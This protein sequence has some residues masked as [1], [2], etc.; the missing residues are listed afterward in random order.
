VKISERIARLERD[1]R[2]AVVAAQSGKEWPHHAAQELHF[3]AQCIAVANQLRV[4]LQRSRADEELG[5]NC[6]AERA[7]G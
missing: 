2:I 4:R 3:A 7:H 1:A 6:D 5:D